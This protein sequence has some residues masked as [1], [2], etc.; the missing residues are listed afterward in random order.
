MSAL[1]TAARMDRMYGLQRHLYDVT[2]RYYLLGRD[3]LIATLDA[4]PGEA[5]CEV[6]CGTGRNLVKAARRYPAT[7]WY[8]VDPSAEMLKTARRSLHRSGL[9]GRVSLARAEAASLVPARDLGLERGLDGAF[10]SY[11]LSMVPQWQEAIDH[12]LTL[13]RPGGTLAAVD[14]G[15]QGGLPRWF[16]RLLFAWLARFGVQYRPEVAA[17]FRTLAAEGAGH[18]EIEPLFRG[19]AQ[20]IQLEKA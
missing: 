18:L 9:G 5:F 2:R 11:T 20:L 8:G 15:D 14:F 1:D 10:F 7:A 19:Y 17:H 12:T 6:G 3:R 16:R 13:V 4:G